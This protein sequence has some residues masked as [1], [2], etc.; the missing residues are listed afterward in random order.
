MKTNNMF[1]IRYCKKCLL[2]NSRPGI[3]IGEDGISNV[4]KDSIN[5]KSD[6]DWNKNEKAFKELVK[7]AKINSNGYDCLVPVSG[8]K[9][10]TWQ[11]IKCLEY[12]LNILAVT[13]KTPGRTKIG[14]KNLDN[15][16][17]LGVDHIDYQINPEVEKKFMYKS[18]KKYGTTGLPMHMALFNIPLKIAVKF[19]T[20]IVIWGENPAAEYGSDAPGFN[21]FKM[22]SEWLKKFGVMHG[23]TAKDWIS[24]DLSKKELTPYFGPTD[25][26]LEKAGVRAV[27]LG[28]YF[29]WDPEIS[30]KVS[31][32]NGFK[33]R[34]KGPKT[35]FYNYADIDDDFISIHH[36]LKWHKFGFT[37]LFDN[38][39]IEIKN[40]RITKEEA[41]EIIRKEGTQEPFEDIEKLCKFLKITKKHFYEIVET[42]RNKNIWY[43]EKNK[44]K[45]KNFPISDWKW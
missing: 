38:L 25:K 8:G 1:N 4:W 26:E 43:K 41:I 17:S 37:R 14:Q 13:W 30:L 39:A 10:S 28:Q 9:D 11:V 33:V 42:F 34:E 21:G 2:P 18:F 5:K 27:F 20:P 45:I 16:V 19:K 35:G 15:L 24:K 44:W 7:Y 22:D 6:I 31:K 40:G 32:K 3:T 36:F 12:G 23:T 29:K